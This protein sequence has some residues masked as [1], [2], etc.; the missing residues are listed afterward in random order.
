MIVISMVCCRITKMRRGKGD[1]GS[2]DI[3]VRVATLNHSLLEAF[4][5]SDIA[6]DTAAHPC[7]LN[8]LPLAVFRSFSSFSGRARFKTCKKSAVLLL[9]L[10]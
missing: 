2:T 7:T 3:L 9:I 6:C 1:T 8:V 10:E 4:I 5:V